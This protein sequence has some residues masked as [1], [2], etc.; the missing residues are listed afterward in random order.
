MNIV[1][2]SRCYS[3]EKTKIFLIVYSSE[4][5]SRSSIESTSDLD[6]NVSR[7]ETRTINKQFRES[8]QSNSSSSLLSMKT[9]RKI[10][11]NPSSSSYTITT[12]DENRR[13][14]TVTKTRQ[15]DDE[16]YELKRRRD[17]SE[18]RRKAKE[19]EEQRRR[20][21]AKARE[22]RDLESL[23]LRL[24]ELRK[25]RYDLEKVRDE[26]IKNLKYVHQRVTLR[27][28]EARDM[29]K[30]KYFQEKKKTPPIEGQI[31]QLK[32]DLDLIHSKII[33]IIDNECKHSAQAGCVHE[34]ETGN[35]ILQ[36]LRTQYETQN[37]RQQLDQA[38]LRLTTDLKLRNQAENECR[39][40]KHELSQAKMNLNYI[41][42]RLT[43]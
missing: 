10:R 36:I 39:S 9:E 33:Q 42:N 24:Q 41:K 23:R 2:C 25:G 35:L 13:A 37:T 29:W 11:S 28:K 30:K 34:A 21:L 17:L 22:P 7:S 40:L 43:C 38:K 8:I 4:I 18:E 27:R 6:S 32:T 15:S 20:D 26:I 16:T 19:L 14:A 12:N 1:S 3:I 5:L 31:T